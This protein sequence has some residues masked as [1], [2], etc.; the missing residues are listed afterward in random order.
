MQVHTLPTEQVPSAVTDSFSWGHDPFT[1]ACKARPLTDVGWTFLSV[2]L[3][4]SLSKACHQEHEADQVLQARLLKSNV[5]CEVSQMT[6]SELG[7]RRQFS[8]GVTANVECFYRLQ[9]L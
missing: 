4:L 8:R 3:S 5:E 2:S 1:H 6:V 7:T 9:K